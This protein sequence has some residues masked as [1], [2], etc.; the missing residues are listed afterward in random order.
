MNFG[1]KAGDDFARHPGRPAKTEATIVGHLWI[2]AFGE[3]WSGGR[4]RVPCAPGNRQERTFSICGQPVG[5][6]CSNER[7][8]D[9]STYNVSCSLR[10]PLVRHIHHV[11]TCQ[12]LEEREQQEMRTAWPE[13][14]KIQF[15]R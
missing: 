1:V 13:R 7:E 5:G 14:G 15:A 10:G 3:G 9:L 8:I 11:D 6:G 4:E 2:A 12:L